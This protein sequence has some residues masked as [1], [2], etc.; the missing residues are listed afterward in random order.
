MEI[1]VI[2]RKEDWGLKPQLTEEDHV[3]FHELPNFGAN[4]VEIFKF[5]RKVKKCMVL[6]WIVDQGTEKKLKPLPA[7]LLRPAIRTVVKKPGGPS[8]V[9]EDRFGTALKR[10]GD[11]SVTS[12]EDYLNVMKEA[13]FLGECGHPSIIYK[14]KKQKQRIDWLKENVTGRVLE[15]GCSTGFVLNYVGGGVGVDVDKL[16]LEYAKKTYPQS[17]FSFADA[18]KMSFTD[19]EFDTVMIPD[20]LEHVEMTH[21]ALIV[22]EAMRVAKKLIITV[23]NAGKPNYD[24]ALVE[25]PEHRWFPTEKL[26]GEMV[27]QGA[28]ITFSPDHDFIYVVK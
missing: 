24:E 9:I 8:I 25:N 3:Y 15:I 10:L 20:I 12:D 27:G 21:A 11:I 5:F 7:W 13:Y 23:P 6:Y 19:K 18:A 22:K 17:Q 14:E 28:Q 26:M 1:N 16:R 2:G 4:P